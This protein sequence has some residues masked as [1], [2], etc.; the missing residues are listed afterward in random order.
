MPIQFHQLKVATVR[1]ETES[2]VQIGFKIPEDKKEEF[3]FEPGQYLTISLNINDKKVRR[4]YS[5]CSATHESIISILVKRVEHGLV[6][7][8]LNDHIKVG[9][10]F[11]VL[12]PNG[13][14]KLTIAKTEKR[15]YFLFGAGSGIT[16]LVSMITSLLESEPLAYCYLLYGNRDEDNIIFQK[17]LDRLHLVYQDR[18]RLKYILSRPKK[19]IAKGNFMFFQSPKVEWQGAIGWV[20]KNS[21]ERFIENENPKKDKINGYFICGPNSMIEA[22]YQCLI[23]MKI[24]KGL[25]HRE[26]FSALVEDASEI[27]ISSVVREQINAKVKVILEGKEIDLNINDDI[28]I[29]QALLDKNIEPPYSCLSGTCS[30]CMAKLEKGKVTMDASIGLE[31][32]EKE[33][34]FILTCQSHPLTE[35]VVINYDQV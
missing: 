28:N 6:S 9:T 20:D 24:E 25:I 18:F 4:A 5:I 13:N 22:S 35:V 12:P 1:Y 19:T 14:F 3:Q 33:N 26:Y 2:A 16:P 11:D 21:I 34:G 32:D 17:K 31:D 15:H 29:V 23:D 27:A 30:T 8:H 7:N 10:T